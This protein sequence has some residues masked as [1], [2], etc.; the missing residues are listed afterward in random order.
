MTITNVALQLEQLLY[1]GLFALCMM[2]GFDLMNAL[3][4]QTKWS[5]RQRHMVDFLFVLVWG[6]LFCIILIWFSNGRLRNYNVL[7]LFIGICVYCYI[8]RRPYQTIC[9]WSASV[10]LWSGH[11]MKRVLFYPWHWLHRTIW[12]PIKRKW[13]HIRRQKIENQL[14]E[15]Q[16]EKII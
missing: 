4:A 14:Q 10:I 8:L 15:E 1:M 5:P 16:M 2:F 12:C 6:L 13:K 3:R 9:K 11:K 7:G